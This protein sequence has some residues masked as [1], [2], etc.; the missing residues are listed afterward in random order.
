MKSIQLKKIIA[1]IVFMPIAIALL[2]YVFMLLWNWLMP[3][4][5][6]LNTITFWQG[7]GLLLLSKII[8]SKW[9]CGYRNKLKW[10]MEEKFATM[11]AEE[12]ECFKQEMRERCK[13]WGSNS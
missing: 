11:T 10:K 3:A 6:G 8:F 4:I 2:A 13:K 12:K 9:G 7:A 1:F 5:F